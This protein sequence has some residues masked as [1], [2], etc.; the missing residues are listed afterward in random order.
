MTAAIYPLKAN[1]YLAMGLP[2]V[3]TPFA[4]LGGADS[5]VY[6]AKNA[7]AFIASIDIALTEKEDWLKQQRLDIA[8]KA[9]WK[10]RSDQLM[11]IIEQYHTSETTVDANILIKSR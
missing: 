4:S 9:D 6:I 1:E 7:K 10:Q 8:K 2:V 5:V 11:E 3:V